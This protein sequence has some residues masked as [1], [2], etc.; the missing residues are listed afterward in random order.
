MPGLQEPNQVGKR[1]D[2]SDYIT[3]IERSETPLFTMLPKDTVH[4]TK[5][6]TQVDDY[7][8]TDDINGVGSGEDVTSFD[9]MAENRGIIEN[10]V[11]KMRE[12]P[13]VDDLAE[14][15]SENPALSKGEYAEAVRKATIRLKFRVEKRALSQVEGT[16]QSG[17][18]K[19]GTCSI[20]GFLKSGAPTGAQIVPE[21][22]RPAA[23]QVYTGTLAALEESDVNNI[24]QEVFEAT[25]GMGKF[26]APVG[27][28]L[29]Q[30]ISLMSIYQ[31]DK[32]SNTVVRRIN[33]S[34]GEVLQTTVDIM[35]GD[36]G[37]VVLVPCTRM[38]Y[39]D[40]AGAATTTAQ[41]R[42]SGYILDL[43]K[44]GLTFKRTPGHR[45]LEDQGG[46]PRGIVDTIFGLRAKSPKA[47]G[48]IL[49]SA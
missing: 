4:N 12:V 38:R 10:Y 11:M 18:T 44:W 28:E 14:N 47:N 32:A 39:F 35:V 49:V 45:K 36:F 48:A 37:R 8:D 34:A 30:K 33:Q 15:V 1:Q 31:P 42:G 24:A 2:L 41:R 46:G 7:G 17:A 40:G 27:S 20:G 16:A 23:A 19:Y 5:F 3:N 6:E 26:H 9:N 29:K 25:N 21:R 43:S 13:M 22:F